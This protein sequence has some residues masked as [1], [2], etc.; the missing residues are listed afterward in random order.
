MTIA[1]IILYWAFA[2]WVGAITFINFVIKPY[3]SM[4]TK[5]KFTIKTG[6]VWFYITIWTIVLASPHV[7]AQIVG[8]A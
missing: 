8:T 3:L 1:L 2:S 6:W 4:S 7:Y 5:G